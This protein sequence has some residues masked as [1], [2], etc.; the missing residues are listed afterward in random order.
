MWLY[1][2]E[3]FHLLSTDA[4]RDISVK[5]RFFTSDGSILEK[6]ESPTLGLIERCS[7]LPENCNERLSASLFVI[8]NNEIFYSSEF[9]VHIKPRVR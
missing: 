8:P 3:L 2:E 6:K 5:L 7:I 9:G 1:I 4:P